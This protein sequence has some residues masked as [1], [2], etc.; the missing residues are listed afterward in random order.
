[1]CW[2]MVFTCIFAMGSTF[3]V[4]V[5][6]RSHGPKT[7]TIK[8]DYLYQTFDLEEEEN[9]FYR[10]DTYSAF[11]NANMYWGYSNMQ[12][13]HSIIPAA[14]FEFYDSINAERM[15]N[16]TIDYSYYGL[17]GLASVKYHIR[18]ADSSKQ[19]KQL[20]G[21]EYIGKQG[22]YEIYE[23]KYYIPMGF[24]YDYYFDKE[25]LGAVDEK[26]DALYVEALY[27]TDEQIEKYSK[28]MEELPLTK[29]FELTHE[30]YLTACE[31]LQKTA[32]H[33]FK[34]DNYG[35]TA[36]A[37]VSDTNLMVFSVPYDSGW[38]ATVN[39]KSVEIEKVQNGFMAV[40]VPEGQVDIRFTYQT[41]GLKLGLIIT[42]ACILLFI[43]YLVFWK[44]LKKVRPDKFATNRYA[45]LNLFE[46]VSEVELKNEYILDAASEEIGKKEEKT[47]K[48]SADFLHI[49]PKAIN[50]FRAKKVEEAEPEI[51]EIILENEEEILSEETRKALENL[52]GIDEEENK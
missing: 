20:P 38:S 35:F 42:L 44:I 28:Y 14:S 10:I 7:K 2:A 37:T 45:H 9:Q 17:R 13:F 6:G 36:K 3:T 24:T 4:M 32:C 40:L 41:P 29:K 26:I 48:Q 52:G 21:F 12:S 18:K 23:N 1:M 19:Y 27:L 22:V 31:R 49:K 50:A 33:Y 16:T 15:V 5:L 46:T 47:K 8:E 34:Y 39:G 25:Q 43:L 11:N 51:D 30:N